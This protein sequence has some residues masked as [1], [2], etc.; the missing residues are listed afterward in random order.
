[1]TGVG[2]LYVVRAVERSGNTEYLIGIYGPFTGREAADQAAKR[3]SGGGV[4]TDV[5]PLHQ[6]GALGSW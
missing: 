6:P 5:M 1:M 2:R 4:L 3:H